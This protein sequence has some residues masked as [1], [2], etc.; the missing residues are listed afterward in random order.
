MHG[1][2]T[3]KLLVNICLLFHEAMYYA[4]IEYRNEVLNIRKV[5]LHLN[6]AP[7]SVLEFNL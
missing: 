5:N 6:I 7:L 3:I 1:Q 4:D 2:K